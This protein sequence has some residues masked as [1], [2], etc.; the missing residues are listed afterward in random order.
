MSLAE[1]KRAEM[2]RR[3]KS[4]I[5]A[6]SAEAKQDD[7]INA[8]ELGRAHLETI[9]WAEKTYNTS[10]EKGLK[11]SQL[12]DIRAQ[13]GWNQLTPPPVRPWYLKFFDNMT[14]LF[15][16]LLW[17][18]SA[19][20]FIAVLIDETQIEYL[21]LAIVLAVVVFMTGCFS[22]YQDAKAD[23][24]MEGFKNMMPPAVL[25]I[26]DGNAAV[27]MEAKELCVGDLVQVKNGDKCP[28]DIRII[29]GNSIEVDNSSLTGENLP[30][31]RNGN[32][33]T[34]SEDASPLEAT[35]ILY[36]GTNMVNGDCLG[37]VIRTGD[38]T[39]MG[40]IAKLVQTAEVE[41]TP[42]AIEIHHFILI[43]SYVAVFLG[44]TFVIIGFVKEIPP[45]DNLVFGIGI[46]VANVPEGLL[47]T[48]TLSLTLTSKRMHEKQV[49]VKNLEAVETLGSTTVIASDKT[50][51]LTCN[52][53][54]V[55][56]LYYDCQLKVAAGDHTQNSTFSMLRDILTLQNSA[57]FA[58]GEKNMQLHPRSRATNGD[59]TESA[60]LKYVEEVWNA[61]ESTVMAK[62]SAFPIVT[63]GKIP[64]NSKNKFAASIHD[65]GSEGHKLLMK[66]APG[67][68][69]ERCEFVLLEGKVT[70]KTPELQ[71]K[72]ADGMRTLM[73]QGQRV[74]GCAFLE[75]DPEDRKTQGPYEYDGSQEKK[76]QANFPLHEGLVFVGLAALMDPP[77]AAVPAAVLCCKDARIQVIMVTGDHPDTAEA[78]ARQVFIINGLTPRKMAENNGEDASAIAKYKNHPKV[79]AQV[80]TGA[81]LAQMTDDEVDHLLDSKE[82]V[83]ARTSP[84][85]K[86]RIVRAL[87]DKKVVRRLG[88]ETLVRHVVAVTGDGVNDSP[89]LKQANIGIAMGIV[90]SDVAK[91][92]AD[93]ILIDDNFA[94]LVQGVEEGRLIFDNLKKSIAYTLSS[95]IPEISPFL[96]FILVQIPLPLPTVL[97]L[98]I[99]LGTDMVPA[100]SLA[101]ENKEANIMHKPPRDMNTDR[102]VTAKLVVFSYLQIG[103][104]QA[105]AGFYTY[106]VVLN[107][108]GFDPSI[109]P[110][111]APGFLS[112][113]LR[114]IGGPYTYLEYD[115]TMH[116]LK[117]CNI[118]MEGVCHNPE[119]ALAHAQCAFFISIIVVQWADLICCK[120]RELSLMTQ[121]MRNGWLN[122][123]LA[124]E[125]ALGALLCYITVFNLPF[126]TRPIHALHWVPAMPF[127]AII[128]TYDETRKYLMRTL[129]KNNW[130]WRN[131]YY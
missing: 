122:F 131:T 72:I 28:A 66:G 76:K 53:M 117:P 23:A 42:I 55:V 37:F 85:Q 61:D 40:Q 34:I 125:T 84:A 98:C 45:V 101:Y 14:G 87:Q 44:V 16:L 96:L 128:L 118:E 68:V 36:Y 11:S 88:K 104:I 80:C 109:L 12:D 25:V 130:V 5:E 73:M 39:A 10:S 106:F 6:L 50:G 116:P 49:L 4:A 129:E 3:S 89:A 54:T 90:G 100:I 31:K 15:S 17:F 29:S 58:A 77:R 105:V 59:A 82:I 81:E 126:G 13:Y 38:H 57:T 51:T 52:R 60:M 8:S 107:D 83:F 21:Y 94:S 103:I 65:F 127:C 123:G 41:E 86:L 99:D 110:W 33:S 91:D 24:V 27:S 114:P 95:N 113:N 20:C 75:L 18:A 97:I 119:E 71:A 19:L 112:E 63:G 78:I 124:W 7:K 93:M 108:Y 62:R 121:G 102:L 2:E 46:I 9:E 26:R 35:N 43:V 32:V 69:L 64:F 30:Q 92:S 48:V 79:T 115:G 67:Q 111:L 56:N 70:P 1:R 74:L 22:Y 120:T 47:A